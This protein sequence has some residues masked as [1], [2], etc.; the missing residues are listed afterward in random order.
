METPG[1]EEFSPYVEAVFRFDGWPETL[2]LAVVEVASRLNPGSDRPSFTL[3][4]RGKRNPVMPEGMRR[5]TA[6]DGRAF[7]I[8]LM[9]I[10]TPSADRQ[11]YQAVFN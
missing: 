1:H 9:P 3:V 11:D 7:D 5:A 8:Y 6:P 2:H 4:F 10:H